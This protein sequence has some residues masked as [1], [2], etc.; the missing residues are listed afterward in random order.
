MFKGKN[1]NKKYIR[2]SYL[3]ALSKIPIQTLLIFM[4][5]KAWGTC[6]LDGY[7]T[8]AVYGLS[9][10]IKRSIQ[11]FNSRKQHDAELDLITLS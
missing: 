7:V 2:T 11:Y 5:R 6:G 4:L 8:L 1:G 9:R 3:I 10:F